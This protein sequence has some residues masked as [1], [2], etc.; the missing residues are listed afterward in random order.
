VRGARIQRLPRADRGAHDDVLPHPVE[1]VG[2]LVHRD[3]QE[4]QARV[5]AH[6][7]VARHREARAEAELEVLGD[8]Q[9]DAPLHRHG[10]EGVEQPLAGIGHGLADEQRARIGGEHRHRVGGCL[11]VV[12]NVTHLPMPQCGRLRSYL[13]LVNRATALGLVLAPHR[14]SRRVA[15]EAV[16]LDHEVDR[17]AEVRGVAHALAEDAHARGHVADEAPHARRSPRRRSAAATPT[18]IG[19]MPPTMPHE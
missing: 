6:R 16:V 18:A 15:G 2:E 17:Q 9:L 8:R 5:E 3:Q 1:V 10:L 11:G 19:H 14:A 13:V 12:Q 7:H 4:V